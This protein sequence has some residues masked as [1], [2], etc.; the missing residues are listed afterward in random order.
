M[1]CKTNRI[2][3]C[4]DKRYGKQTGSGYVMTNGM[5]NRQDVAMSQLTVYTADMIWLCHDKRYIK[6]T[7]SDF[8]MIKGMESR[9]D[10]TMS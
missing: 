6:Q 7:G 9:Q 8:V 10:F 1:V 3:L 4:H 5:Y 2:R